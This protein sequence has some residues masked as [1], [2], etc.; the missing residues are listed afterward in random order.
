MSI[1]RPS[2]RTSSAMDLISDL[3]A[4]SDIDTD[5]EFKQ[6][7]HALIKSDVTL[8]T[9]H[10]LHSLVSNTI[11]AKYLRLFHQ[12]QAFLT[13][14][15]NLHYL[16]LSENG[17]S[18][19]DKQFPDYLSE[20]SLSQLNS[21]EPHDITHLLINDDRILDLI[22]D[23]SL[24]ATVWKYM[25][26]P[27]FLTHIRVQYIDGLTRDGNET[28]FH[29]DRDDFRQV[30]MFVYLSD[31]DESCHPH[32]FIADSHSRQFSFEINERHTSLAKKDRFFSDNSLKKCLDILET[33]YKT[34]VGPSG[35]HLLEDTYAL[36][37]RKPAC[38]GK[39]ILLNLTWTTTTNK[40]SSQ[41]SNY[42]FPID[43]SE[44]S[45]FMKYSLTYVSSW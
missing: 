40:R 35:T 43:K 37:R 19:Y 21:N 1:I 11:L 36:H 34:F 30:K 45:D 10:H 31:V 5:L 23:P 25:R 39:R 42:N 6:F 8:V 27:V 12:S 38:S 24:H 15:S 14:Q 2:S 3:L 4:T 17:Y 7:Y 22:C 16:H 32:E 44:L 33:D 18:R 41:L 28:Y 26:C 9:R 29:R 20:L 13:E